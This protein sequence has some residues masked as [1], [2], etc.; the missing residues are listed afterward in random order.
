M[1]KLGDPDHVAADPGN[2]AERALPSK[3]NIQVTEVLPRVAEGGAFIKFSHAPEEE[4]KATERRVRDFLKDKPLK[5][6][7]NPFQRVRTS[8]VLGRPWVEDL[9]RWPDPRVK[10][11][12]VPASAGQPVEELSQ[13]TLYS[14]FR[15]YG[16]LADIKPQ[17]TDSKDL[18]KF[19]YLT[20]G[21]S[22]TRSWPRIACMDSSYL[23]ARVEEIKGQC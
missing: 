20:S 6:W 16:K 1:Q 23:L 8:L 17:P 19:A 22:G 18:P 3:L 21:R 4:A 2:I 14:L 11:E 5:P 15:R 7:F 10:V 12:F 13:E 9:H